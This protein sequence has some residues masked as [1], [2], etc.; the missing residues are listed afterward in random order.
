MS[1]SFLTTSSI[2]PSPPLLSNFIVYFVGV[3]VLSFQTA[4][5]VI[6]AFTVIVSP[7]AFSSLPT[8][9]ALNSL[10][11]GAVNVQAGNGYLSP[12]FLTT[13]SIVPSPP[14]LSNFIVYVFGV[15]G[16]AGVPLF[17]VTV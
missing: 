12:S 14:L 13:S 16:G 8:S 5:I 1:P 4:I 9:Q 15:G 6:S 17:I 2:V 11:V 7:A 10:F 3:T